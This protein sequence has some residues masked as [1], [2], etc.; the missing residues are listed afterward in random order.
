MLANHYCQPPLP[1]A[2]ANCHCRYQPPLPTATANRRCQPP[3]PTTAANRRCQLHTCVI[4]THL[5][6]THKCA[7]CNELRGLFTSILG[8]TI[9]IIHEEVINAQ[10]HAVSSRRWHSQ[11]KLCIS[12][13]KMLPFIS[14]CILATCRHHVS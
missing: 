1:T 6:Q 14:S 7:G 8:H 9:R 4:G 3:L 5:C 12:S 2:I 11:W 13:R 10:P